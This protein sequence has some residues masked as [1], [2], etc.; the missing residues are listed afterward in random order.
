M[1]TIPPIGGQPFVVLP[2]RNAG[3]AVQRVRVTPDPIESY[4]DR[5]GYDPKFIVGE[6][7]IGLPRM[8]AAVKRDA[9][10]FTRQGR[11]TTELAYT[12]FSVVVSMSRRMPIF[13]A[14]NIDAS[15]AKTIKRTD[16]WKYDPRIPKEYQLL[17]EVYG[18]QKDGYFSRGH[19]T[20][21]QDPDWGTKAEA[22]VADADTFHATNA[23]PQVQGFNDG[24]W[25]DIEDYIL[26]NAKKDAMRI[27]VF[28]GPVFA[29]NDPVVHGVKI[30]VLFWKVV[31]FIN[32]ET[33]A[34]TATGYVASQASAIA[35]L[36]PA[37]VF[38]DFQHQQ[39]PLV[40]I[41]KLA[42]LTFPELAPL[43]V[44][45]QAGPGFAARLRDVRD[46][47]LA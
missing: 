37:F 34:L 47:M 33:G 42:G 41:E 35:D 32:D 22:T 36:R 27:S 25:G 15:T 2:G 12:H 4:Q 29:K 38:G 40:A 18:N 44:L 26:A 45:A 43:D 16:I 6:A 17:K 7:A 19:M 8:K 39:R 1:R 31:A 10:N 14:C 13:S 46:I 3:T 5:R 9:A 20:R 24:L 23:A 11:K 30:P 28:T 21:R